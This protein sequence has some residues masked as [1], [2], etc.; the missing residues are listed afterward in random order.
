MATR[1]EPL[2][3]AE[4]DVSRMLAPDALDPLTK[5]RGVSGTVHAGGRVVRRWDKFGWQE[6]AR[7]ADLMRLDARVQMAWQV[8]ASELRAAQWTVKAADHPDGERYAEY[9]RRALGLDGE[10]G[11]MRRTWGEFIDEGVWFAY[12]GALPFE[13]VWQYDARTGLI[14][15]LDIESR[16]PSSILR[17]GDGD[18]LGPLVQ[19]QRGDG[20]RP[21][22]IPGKRLL[23][24]TRGK[25]GS[26]WTGNGLAR[27]A[28]APWY[29][30]DRIVD[31]RT[32]ALARL[33]VI[34]P[35]VQYDPQLLS[36]MSRGNAEMPSVQSL[37]AETVAQ[38]DA[39][40]AG[41]RATLVTIKG[42]LEVAWN[43]AANFDPA[44]LIATDER[45]TQDIYAAFGAEFLAMGMSTH[46]TGNRSLGE[47]HEGLLRRMSIEDAD[48][49]ACAINGKWRPGGGLV[50]AVC[51]LNA[52]NYDPAAQPTVEHQG[53]EPDSFADSLQSMPGLIASGA[54][55]PDDGLESMTRAVIGAPMLERERSTDDRQAAAQ[56]S[57]S[58]A[59][60]M[61][62]LGRG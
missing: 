37:V 29:R 11:A 41:Q 22:P 47:M 59:R 13:V 6:W 46:S 34:A 27:A 5:R 18:Q 8:R 43:T 31:L 25:L 4:R 23:C 19:Y 12:Y 57:R 1:T 62:R 33:G 61:A 15:P 30:R 3:D 28:W 44:P 60:I 7:Q 40:D 16:I 36:D 20:P 45:E 50:G 17:W 55:T 51:Q 52:P 21:E 42:A 58:T 2:I 10:S 49:M 35:E 56:L 24:F 14:A 54:L 48:A 32:I 9:V 39:V 38:V 53:L 26:D